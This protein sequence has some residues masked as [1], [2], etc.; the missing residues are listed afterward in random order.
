MVGTKTLLRADG[1]AGGARVALWE[2]GGWG[3]W[4]WPL[5]AGWA[6]GSATRDVGLCKAAGKVLWWHLRNTA[7]ASQ[8]SARKWVGREKDGRGGVGW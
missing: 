5:G 1:A 8:R 6:G 3:W 2:L 7:T 4:G